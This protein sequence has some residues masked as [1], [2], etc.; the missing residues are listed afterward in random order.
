MINKKN[1][2]LS[3]GFHS[4]LSLFFF[5]YEIIVLLVEKNGSHINNYILIS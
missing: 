5:I 3:L 1:E 2:E 4:S